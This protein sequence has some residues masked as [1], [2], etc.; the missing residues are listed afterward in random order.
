MKHCVWV[1]GFLFWVVPLFGIEGT[2][3][4]LS[5]GLASQMVGVGIM[6]MTLLH[7]E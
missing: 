4:P 7:K 6:L 2:D 3:D 1:I 5:N